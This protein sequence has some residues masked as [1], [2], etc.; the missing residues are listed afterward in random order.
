MDLQFKFRESAFRHNVTEA[1]I[2][3]AEGNLR[4]STCRG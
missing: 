1:D 3:H 2:R 4:L